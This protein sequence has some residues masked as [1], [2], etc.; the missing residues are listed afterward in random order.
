MRL[1]CNELAA[2]SK[3]RLVF[4]SGK[5]S[6]LK[7]EEQSERVVSVEN[8]MPLTT[9]NWSV[10]KPSG[11][12]L[13][14]IQ[15]PYLVRITTE[16]QEEKAAPERAYGFLLYPPASGSLNDYLLILVFVEPRRNY[17]SYN[18]SGVVE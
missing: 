18:P 6:L 7:N 3:K 12:S 13:K 8:Q 17:G 14:P 15:P 16:K 5:F 10:L 2:K 11:R 1:G 4:S 9:T